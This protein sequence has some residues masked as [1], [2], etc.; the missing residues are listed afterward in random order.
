MNIQNKIADRVTI[1]QYFGTDHA[2]TDRILQNTN[3]GFFTAHFGDQA[4]QMWD[5]AH[6]FYHEHCDSRNYYLFSI[7]FIEKYFDLFSSYQFYTT[8]GW[9]DFNPKTGRVE[10]VY[11]SGYKR[12]INEQPQNDYFFS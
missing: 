7:D 5:E 2:T 12:V 11:K 4:K 1:Q 8:A 3:W 9:G 6:P 10:W